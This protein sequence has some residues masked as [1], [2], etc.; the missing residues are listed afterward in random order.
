[1][2]HDPEAPSTERT[3][4]L[5]F[6]PEIA[7]EAGDFQTLDFSGV[8]MRIFP[9]RANMYRLQRFCDDYLN[10]APKE[11]CRW[12]PLAP[13]V[14]F[15]VINYGRMGPAAS[16]LGWVSQN[17]ILFSVPLVG[18][19]QE[20]WN[21]K[22]HRIEGFASV[23]PF[24]WVDN[25]WSITT[26]REVYGWPKYI[27]SFEPEINTWL[28][29]PRLPRRLMRLKTPYFA[30]LY[31]GERLRRRTLLELYQASPASL[32]DFPPDVASL[33]SPMLRMPQAMI[34]TM[35]A[36]PDY[37]RVFNRLWRGE[38]A[39][40]AK[41]MSQ[42]VGDW[43]SEQP[44]MFGNT[45]NLKQ[46]RASRPE[47]VAYQSLVNSRILF[48]RFGGAGLL[49]ASEQLRG[50]PTG[51]FKLRIHESGSFPIIESLGIEVQNQI[52]VGR[53]VV[54]EV[55]PLAPS[56]LSGDLQYT[57]GKRVAW[58][59][60]RT[61]W[62][63]GLESAPPP[64]V[65][66]AE[67]QKRDKTVTPYNTT[68]GPVLGSVRGPFDFYDTEM[69]V[70]PL[71]ADRKVLSQVLGTDLRSRLQTAWLEAQRQ[72]LAEIKGRA[73]TQ[74]REFVESFGGDPEETKELVKE[75]EAKLDR[76][77]ERLRQEKGGFEAGFQA[78]GSHAFLV[79]T[80]YGRMSGEAVNLGWWGGS[81][82]A[83]AVVFRMPYIIGDLVRQMEGLSVD[84]VEPEHSEINFVYWPFHFADSPIAVTEG[85][86][87]LGLPTSYASIERGTSAW[88]ESNVAHAG[89]S[90]LKVS[91]KDY[92]AVGVG[93]RSVERE[94]LEIRGFDHHDGANLVERLLDFWPEQ[95]NGIR[96][97]S[98]SLKQ[99]RDEES[100]THVSYRAMVA[101]EQGLGQ[102]I[103][104]AR[105]EDDVQSFADSA[106]PTAAK[107]ASAGAEPE[108][109][110]FVVANQ[111]TSTRLRL[112]PLSGGFEVRFH[113]SQSWPL[114]EALGLEVERWEDDAAGTVAVC[115]VENAFRLNG[116]LRRNLPVCI[117]Q[118]SLD[119]E[120]Q[121]GAN[122]EA[123]VNRRVHGRST[124]AAF[125]RD[126]FNLPQGLT[127]LERVIALLRAEHLL[128]FLPLGHQEAVDVA[129]ELIRAGI[130]TIGE[131]TRSD[132]VRDRLC[133]IRQAAD[134]SSDKKTREFMAHVQEN[135]LLSIDD[136]TPELMKEL[137]E[138]G[139]KT[140][141]DIVNN[142]LT[143]ARVVCCEATAAAIVADA[144]R[145]LGA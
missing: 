138:E 16:N 17:E 36:M 120:W 139:V 128:D 85:R 63:S 116:D 34:D 46:F 11:M 30:Q 89:R 94:L 75:T 21:G 70:L 113:D 38:D 83:F 140:A 117:Y 74:L 14:L 20:A 54:A 8:T 101:F 4:R 107:A 66:T 81:E 29:D 108:V 99:F 133:D 13:Y 90:L 141:W 6:G 82:V 53:R 2:T 106:R 10:I 42:L 102:W 19:W 135:V 77:V 61:G 121:A 24:I 65:L 39:P 47:A 130:E 31:E 98:L 45:I 12:E 84:G 87:V 25:E 37:L 48:K 111:A 41:A 143:V 58:R 88:L 129:L 131:L 69:R 97:S 60:Q 72:A 9:L 137:R 23:S 122:S 71:K 40:M 78:V 44:Q 68:L 64:V 91:T 50:D 67:E 86:E 145:V 104:Y 5:L 112:A 57:L 28:E 144:R 1:M 93:A 109:A 7:L 142:Q 105:R 52:R 127:S 134:L 114:V 124:D 22:L 26:G 27:A 125:D 95:L 132:T 115:R 92:P 18:S 136:V 43:D 73:G 51:G 123:Y 15:M 32:G 33:L 126:F 79:I 62:A 3:S 59:L 55:E 80:N 35:S 96:Y 110:S 103:D 56:W 49:G 118:Q 76:E 119:G 100:P